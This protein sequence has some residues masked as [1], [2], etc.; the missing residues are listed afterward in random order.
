M[1]F[2]DF[3][4]QR[5]NIESIQQ[6]L[7]QLLKAFP[8]A[9]SYEEQH[10]MIKKVNSIREQFDSM[11]QL[12][13]V[14]HT[15]DTTDSFYQ[16]EQLFF[17]ETEPTFQGWI[18]KYYRKLIQSSYRSKLEEQWG[19]QLFDLAQLNVKTFSDD[20]LV[21]LKEENRLNT[22]YTKLLASA[23]IP[24]RGKVYNLSELIPFQQSADRKIRK[25]ASE[26]KYAFFKH[27]EEKF[28]MLYDRMVKTRTTIAQKL[29]F[30][31]F[32]E[33]GYTRLN[34]TDYDEKDVAVF[35]KQ[36][37][38]IIVPAATNLREKQRVRLGV[39]NLKYFD[40]GI[41]FNTGNAVPKGDADWILQNGLQM[42]A[43]L[44]K[45][46]KEFFEYMMKYQLMDL[47]TKKGKSHGGYCTYISQ[48]QAPFIFSNFNGTAED[49]DV[50]THEA[51]H[52]FQVYSSRHFEIPEYHWPTLDAC[53]IHSMS[54]EF[55]TYPWMDRFFKEDTEK[56]KYAHI[57]GALLFI[58]YGV[59][60]DEFQHLVYA[61][62]EY[63][64]LQ[65]R[66]AWRELEKTYLPHRNYD[67]NPYLEEGG[68]WHQQGHIFKN[69]F[70]YIDYTLAQIC[71]FQFWNLS[72]KNFSK[73]W[74]RYLR[75][76]KAG[77][78]LPFTGL[79]EQAEL[80]S[81]FEESTVKKIITEV[82][83]NLS[84]IDKTQL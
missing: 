76:C 40:E 81:P 24:F 57:S 71:A 72:I 46:T 60:V 11:Q 26:A 25:E 49:L 21:E 20:V 22:E 9:K 4:Y 2:N 65:R 63:T 29:G 16:A 8:H 44:S 7:T 19:K 77:G 33:L 75:L 18:S 27:N 69:P 37:E 39:D 43:E 73:A 58:P 3:T 48:Y 38:E 42:Y 51:G 68:Y 15:I 83:Q 23:R 34:R 78:S 17:D 28:D 74:E 53:E 82:L 14:R 41:M 70:Y 47:L 31:N 84:Q 61:H 36:V 67:G 50:L 10:D 13:Y 52:A 62:A 45:E 80:L 54:M 59:T 1:K 66:K 55:L 35:R 12:A 30:K 79:V 32:I 56:Y 64:P 6:Q 5:P